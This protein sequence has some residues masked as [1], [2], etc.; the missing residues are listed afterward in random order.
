MTDSRLTEISTGDQRDTGGESEEGR[1]MRNRSFNS[2][3]KKHL[4]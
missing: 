4:Q 2:E 3:K 1:E